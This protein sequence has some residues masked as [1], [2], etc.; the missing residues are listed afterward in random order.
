MGISVIS[1]IMF[2]DLKRIFFRGLNHQTGRFHRI[3]LENNGWL[4]LKWGVML[5]GD[6]IHK[7]RWPNY[8]LV[9][10]HH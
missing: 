5:P 3:K 9:Y 2:G 8:Q 1:V 6:F 7:K 4:V 10:Q